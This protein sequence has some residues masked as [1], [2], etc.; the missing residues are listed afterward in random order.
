MLTNQHLISH[1]SSTLKTP[2]LINRSV[3]VFSNCF[4]SKLWLGW[5]HCWASRKKWGCQAENVDVCQRYWSDKGFIF[6]WVLKLKYK[7]SE[8]SNCHFKKIYF[9]NR[10]DINTYIDHKTLEVKRISFSTSLWRQENWQIVTFVYFI[11]AEIPW[12]LPPVCAQHWAAI[13]IVSS[14]FFF[15]RCRNSSHW[16][17]CVPLSPKNVGNHQFSSQDLCHCLVWAKPRTWQE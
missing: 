11:S 13:A 8:M 9:H 4:M 14:F 15:E 5:E 6:Y 1:S 16:L 7:W 10:G 17:F 12:A 2:K 3:F